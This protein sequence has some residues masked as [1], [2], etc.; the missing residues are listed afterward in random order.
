MHPNSLKIF[1]KYALDYFQTKSTLKILE[2]SPDSFPSSCFKSVASTYDQA[3]FVWETLGFS[4]TEF[5]SK[6]TYQ[7]NNGYVY[8]IPDNSFDIVCSANVIEHVPMI[9]LW[10]KELSRICKPAG[11]VVTVNPVSWPFHEAP[12]DCWR[13]YPDGMRALYEDSGLSVILSNCESIH[14]PENIRSW[15][16]TQLVPGMSYQVN[17]SQIK[18]Y[19]KKIFKVPVLYATDTITIGQK[20]KVESAT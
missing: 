10:M 15:S 19:L 17:Y 7:T 13:I 12:V 6:Y 1:E 16:P 4:N 20:V 2:I 14:I 18:L 8:P 3:K 5:S 9:W 11:Y